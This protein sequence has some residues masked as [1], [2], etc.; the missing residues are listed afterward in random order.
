MPLRLRRLRELHITR[1]KYQT[2]DFVSMDQYAVKNGGRLPTSYVQE[3]ESNDFHDGTL[4]CD[5]AFKYI[6][7]Q[8]QVSLDAGKQ[9]P[10]KESLRSG[11]GRRVGSR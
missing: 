6:Y 4:F 5:A 2:D 9:S 11:F 10:P 8:S 1:D 7:V 3:H